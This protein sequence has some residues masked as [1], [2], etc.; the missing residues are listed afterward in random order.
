MTHKE[1]KTMYENG[2]SLEA[3]HQIHTSKNEPITCPK[4]EE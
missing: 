2:V 3:I 4:C 1:Y